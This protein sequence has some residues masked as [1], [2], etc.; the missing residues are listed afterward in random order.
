MKLFNK[1]KQK[2]EKYTRTGFI[3][4]CPECHGHDFMRDEYDLENACVNHYDVDGSGVLVYLTCFRCGHCCNQSQ[5]LLRD[6]R[7][8][9]YHHDMDVA[10]EL[11]HLRKENLRLRTGFQFMCKRVGDE[12]ENRTE[13]TIGV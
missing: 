5:V 11:R 12:I 4:E 2:N 10:S 7:D 13:F 6:V 1:K 3:L 8:Y 9:D